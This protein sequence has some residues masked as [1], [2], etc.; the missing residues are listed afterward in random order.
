MV[1]FREFEK[2]LLKPKFHWIWETKQFIVV[3]RRNLKI[4]AA[5]LKREKPIAGLPCIAQNAYCS[6]DIYLQSVKYL[7]SFTFFIIIQINASRQVSLFK[8]NALFSVG[9]MVSLINLKT[10]KY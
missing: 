7:R 2:A 10:A 4:G 1:H 3:S 5:L 6:R 8:I 9:N